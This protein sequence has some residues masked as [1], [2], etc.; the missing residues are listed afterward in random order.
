MTA[1]NEGD[2]Y[3]GIS[4]VHIYTRALKNSEILKSRTAAKIHRVQPSDSC[5]QVTFTIPYEL[6]QSKTDNFVL[7]LFHDIDGH[8]HTYAIRMRPVKLTLSQP[9][10]RRALNRQ[11]AMVRRVQWPQKLPSIPEHNAPSFD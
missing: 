3:I 4:P 8:V 9:S 11:P 10:A 6:S 5:D 7:S 2:W 1:D